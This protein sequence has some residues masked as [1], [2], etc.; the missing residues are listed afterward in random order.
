MTNFYDGFKVETL[1]F[2]NYLTFS[3]NDKVGSGSFISKFPSYPYRRDPTDYMWISCEVTIA[4]GNYWIAAPTFSMT[5]GLYYLPI[6]W[7]LTTT[8]SS[9]ITVGSRSIYYTTDGTEPTNAST[10]YPE[11]AISLDEFLVADRCGHLNQIKAVVYAGEEYSAVTTLSYY[12]A[13]YGITDGSYKY[14]DQEFYCYDVP[15]LTGGRI[16]SGVY[17]LIVVSAPDDLTEPNLALTGGEISSGAYTE[18]VVLAPADLAEPAMALTGGIINQGKYWDPIV[19][20]EPP[21]N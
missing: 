21:W 1:E 10:L 20:I 6:Q 7:P 16:E 3:W 15:A 12:R 9:D 11:S 4:S 8:I 13:Y 18:I 14:T 5:S 2:W 19:E 17:T